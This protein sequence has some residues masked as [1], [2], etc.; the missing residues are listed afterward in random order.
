MISREDF[1]ARLTDN[2]ALIDYNLPEAFDKDANLYDALVYATAKGKRIRASLYF[3][4]LR[5]LGKGISDEDISFATC[6]EMIH[7]Y[8]LVHDD[9]PAMDNDDFRR[10]EKSVHKKYGEDIAILVGDGLL[11]EAAKSLFDLALSKP[12]YLKA[13]QLLMAMAGYKGM[14]YGQVLDLDPN[15]KVDLDYL[16]LVYEKKTSDLFKAAIL[17]AGLVIDKDMEKNRKDD[18]KNLLLYAKNLGL[19]YQIQDDLLEEDYEDELNILNIV[20]KD[21]A[22]EIL[23]TINAK[24]KENI[25]GFA[26]NDFL[27]YLVDYLT[28]RDN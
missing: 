21:Q 2:K 5:M 15:K 27:L 1:L 25:K 26:N 19:A 17:A 14:I 11:T 20:D 12:S 23:A 6:L 24:A 13:G 4:T 16:M 8:S 7:A 10:G 18:F 22:L 3:E 9:L 28:N